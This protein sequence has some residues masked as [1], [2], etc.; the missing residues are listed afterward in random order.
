MIT[1]YSA[2]S[3]FLF[4]LDR[5][6]KPAEH[7]DQLQVSSLPLAEDHINAHDLLSYQM[8]SSPRGYGIIVNNKIFTCGF[9]NREGTD[10]DA[11]ALQQLF[12]HL[13]FSTNCYND[14]TGNQLR[15]IFN[16]AAAAD[17]KKFDCLL[18]AIL[19]CGIEGKLYSTDGELIPVE[20]ITKLFNGDHCP[21]LIGKPKIFLL[22]IDR[23]EN[24]DYGVKIGTEDGSSINT[25]SQKITDKEQCDTVK[26]AQIES[27]I[28]YVGW[29][30]Q[31]LTHT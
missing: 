15:R 21:S 16:D 8:K 31:L 14:L 20:D 28:D 9:K 23:G 29:F 10:K 7:E 17:H 13:G 11:T 25:N 26:K 24:F 5:T 30:Y 2:N 1:N 27:Q 12:T 6:I 3:L 19:T 4:N 22:Q 18:V